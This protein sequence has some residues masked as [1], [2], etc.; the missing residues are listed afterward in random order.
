MIGTA[1]LANSTNGPVPLTSLLLSTLRARHPHVRVTS[2][3]RTPVSHCLLA[4]RSSRDGR[5]NP[6]PS[7]ETPDLSR[8]SVIRTHP[9]VWGQCAK[10]LAS[11]GCPIVGFKD[12]DGVLLPGAALN[13]PGMRFELQDA[14]STSAAAREVAEDGERAE[15]AI[16]SRLAGEAWGLDVLVEGV[17][18]VKG[19]ETRF[20]VLERC[21][22]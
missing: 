16:A 13:K 17:E 6:S 15:L 20:V 7:S 21:E 19:N 9:Q 10:F 12:E 14:E 2:E 8:Y 22:D 4:R 5:A 3:L 18:D 1:P 11:I